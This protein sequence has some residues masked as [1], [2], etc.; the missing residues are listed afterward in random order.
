MGNLK[1]KIG[2]LKGNL[3]F[4]EILEIWKISRILEIPQN[5]DKPNTVSI[6]YI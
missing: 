4:G 2:N 6:Y 3:N 5:Q 1:N